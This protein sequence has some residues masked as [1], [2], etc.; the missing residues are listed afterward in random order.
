MWGVAFNFSS[1]FWPRLC[2]LECFPCGSVVKK[3]PAKAGDIDS[4]PRSG[5]SP[6][7]GNGNPHQYSCLGNPMDKRSLVGYESMGSDMT[8][9]LNNNKK[10]RY[11]D[12][13]PYNTMW[14]P[15]KSLQVCPTLFDPMDCSRPGSSVHGILQAGISEWVA[16][17]SSTGL[18]L[19]QALNLHL[20]CLLH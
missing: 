6:G 12:L 1:P 2:C 18:F 8:Q 9:Q 17:L 5:R 7:E 13:V 11:L 3:P 16:T 4:I 14:V 19:T 15:A 10:M 20:L